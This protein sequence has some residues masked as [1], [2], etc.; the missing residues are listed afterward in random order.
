GDVI[1]YAGTNDVYA[2]H[3]LA[4]ANSVAAAPDP[5]AVLAER[6]APIAFG[7]ARAVPFGVVAPALDGLLGLLHGLV[8]RDIETRERWEHLAGTE[9]P[10]WVKMVAHDPAPNVAIGATSDPSRRASLKSMPRTDL[11]AGVVP[12]GGFV[13]HPE[14]SGTESDQLPEGETLAT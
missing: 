1:A 6:L 7:L 4:A 14:G 5:A 13:L 10:S 12:G 9:E 3:L 2:A 8:T 11:L